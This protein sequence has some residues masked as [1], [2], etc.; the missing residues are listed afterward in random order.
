MD[1]IL[2][3]TISKMSRVLS[4]PRHLVFY[5]SALFCILATVLTPDSVVAE[6]T[7]GICTSLT[8]VDKTKPW[9][10]VGIHKLDLPGGNCPPSHVYMSVQSPGGRKRAADYIQ[11]QG[12]CCPIQ[13]GIL[14]D[15]QQYQ[16]ERCPE[17][18]VATGAKQELRPGKEVVDDR[19]DPEYVL[20]IRKQYL[21]CTKLAD[22]YI[23][24]TPIPGTLV[25]RRT[26]FSTAFD[27]RIA[28]MNIPPALRYGL[29]REGRAQWS[30]S[31]CVGLPWG[32]VLVGKSSKYCDGFLFS[33]IARRSTQ[34]PLQTY[35]SCLA[36]VDYEGETTPRCIRS[37]AEND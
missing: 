30:R 15:E 17:N 16:T 11:V 37:G 1:I 25:G 26:H 22:E 27:E 35:Q 7:P 21:R 23:T 10:S 4:R 8:Y 13:A 18:W 24:L 3:V 36:V 14:S 29:G 20:N 5:L 9:A 33:Q 28:R 2:C 12:T 34:A 19:K 32:S 6:S 31:F